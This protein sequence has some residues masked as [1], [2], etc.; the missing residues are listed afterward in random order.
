MGASKLCS[1][2]RTRDGVV[3]VARQAK[4]TS[5]V[6]GTEV[7]GPSPS[8]NQIMS[9]TEVMGIPVAQQEKTSSRGQVMGAPPSPRQVMSTI[10]DN[11]DRVSRPRRRPS[12]I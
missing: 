2:K 11:R 12:Q 9:W 4:V 7:M 3:L 5:N 10:V 6:N 8:P 1:A